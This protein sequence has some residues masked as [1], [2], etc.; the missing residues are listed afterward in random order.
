MLVV[1]VYCIR[2]MMCIMLVMREYV[3]RAATQVCIILACACST[4]VSHVC[5]DVMQVCV[6]VACACSTGV[7]L[8]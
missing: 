1:R 4:G 7:R 6:V 8:S 2:V 3:C 5:G